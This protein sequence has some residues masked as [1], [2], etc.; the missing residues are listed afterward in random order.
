MDSVANQPEYNLPTGVIGMEECH[1]NQLP[2]RLLQLQDLAVNY[3]YWR[4]VGPGT[5]L[6]YY[7]RGN[8]S[9]GLTPT[10][11][12][13]IPNGIFVVYTSLPPH[14]TSDSDYFT[15]PY[16]GERALISYAKLKA[17]EKDAAGEGARRLEIYT[18]NWQEDL[19]ALRKAVESVSENEATVLGADYAPEQGIWKRYFGFDPML[20]ATPPP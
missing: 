19:M 2:M 11:G 17:A 16:A 1:F 14:P 20:T 6:F 8:S 9:F 7:L 12:T 18:R 13:A 15:C 5:P 3:A 4:R 10:P